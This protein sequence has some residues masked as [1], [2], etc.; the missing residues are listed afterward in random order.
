MRTQT[1]EALL[2]SGKEDDAHRSGVAMIFSKKAAVCLT[3]WSPVKE[4]ISTARFN[5]RYIR[6]AIVQVY[7]PINDADDEAKD[8]QVRNVTEKIPKHD[9]VLLMGPEIQK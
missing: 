1:G 2:Y 8:E 5:L 6:T 4:R 9:I 7:A 3:S